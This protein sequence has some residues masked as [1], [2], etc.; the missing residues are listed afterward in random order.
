MP[1]ILTVCRASIVSSGFLGFFSEI[2][3]ALYACISDL[4]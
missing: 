1:E 3:V 2:K 4:I